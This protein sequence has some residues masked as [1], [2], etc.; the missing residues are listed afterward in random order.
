ME[1]VSLTNRIINTWNNLPNDFV[2]SGDL[3]KNSRNYLKRSGR[4][5]TLNKALKHRLLEQMHSTR[6]YDIY[7]RSLHI[8]PIDMHQDTQSLDENR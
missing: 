6:I 3:A 8:G 2:I 1:R 7:N 5:A 4:T